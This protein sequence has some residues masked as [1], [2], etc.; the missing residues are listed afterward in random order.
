[1]SRI[2]SR[3]AE[4][5]IDDGSKLLIDYVFGKTHRICYCLTTTT[6]HSGSTVSLVLHAWIASY[7]DVVKSRERKREASAL[8]ERSDFSDFAKFLALKV[9]SCRPRRA[10]FQI[11]R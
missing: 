1:M 9:L 6:V 4:E 11:Q 7:P 10:R 3:V 5:V 2:E 8:R